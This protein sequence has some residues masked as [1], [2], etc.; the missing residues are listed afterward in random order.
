MIERLRAASASIE[1]AGIEGAYG[2]AGGAEPFDHSDGC[3]SAQV[4]GP[5]LVG[6]PQDADA[7]MAGGQNPH[8]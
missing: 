2:S 3:A 8:G 5:G 6:K 7:V 4:T 1:H